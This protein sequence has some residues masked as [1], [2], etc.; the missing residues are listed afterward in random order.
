MTPRRSIF[1]RQYRATLKLHMKP[2]GRTK[3]SEAARGMGVEARKAGVA[4][5]DLAEMHSHAVIADHLPGCNGK[6]RVAL[7]K[8]AGA[9]LTQAVSAPD[10]LN[11]FGKDATHNAECLGTLLDRGLELAIS[12]HELNVELT[13]RKEAEI[14]HKKRDRHYVNQLAQSD[15]RKQ[16]LGLLSRQVISAQEEE[17]KRLSRDLH[18]VIAQALAGVNLRLAVL[19]KDSALSNRGVASSISATQQ[20]VEKSA[21]LVYQFARDLRPTALDDLGLAPA[22]HSYLKSFSERTGIRTHLKVYAGI[23]S[24]DAASRIVLYR[25]AQEAITNVSRHAHASH[26]DVLIEKLGTKI[27]MKVK[28]NGKSFDVQRVLL[29]RGNKRLGLLG[30]RERLEM[31]GG[32]FSIESAPGDGTTIIAQIPISVTS[33]AKHRR[34]QVKP[35]RRSR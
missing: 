19:R 17:R 8:R 9:F 34:N 11:R 35:V 3:F 25:V 2:G 23:E 5:P 32:D 22:L 4:W 7:L 27:S 10:S 6:R 12:N 24:L 30:M 33:T 26:V 13:L 20:L 15:L 31:V 28:D 21:A 18:D 14:I 1:E 29:A 16:Q